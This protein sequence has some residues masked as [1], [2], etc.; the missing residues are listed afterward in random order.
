MSEVLALVLIF[1]FRVSNY[2]KGL[3]LKVDEVNR[4]MAGNSLL[5]DLC[6]DMFRGLIQQILPRS[7]AFI[8]HTLLLF[9]DGSTSEKQRTKKG[10]KVAMSW[11]IVLTEVLTFTTGWHCLPKQETK[12]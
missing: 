3:S 11:L 12:T 2:H 5:I 8:T 10:L 4:F 7:H 1:T 6:G 9:Y